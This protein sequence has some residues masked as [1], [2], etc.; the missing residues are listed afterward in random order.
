M[1]ESTERLHKGVA[2][3]RLAHEL[4]SQAIADL[5]GAIILLRTSILS[6]HG[7]FADRIGNMMKSI[8]FENRG[9]VRGSLRCLHDKLLQSRSSELN[10]VAI[11][12]AC[13]HIVGAV[14]GRKLPKRF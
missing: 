14:G 7:R 1:Q 3:S 13:A 2:M 4:L 6:S 11:V 12:L 10:S 5:V 9:E 8:C